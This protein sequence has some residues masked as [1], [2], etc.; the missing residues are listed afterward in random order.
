M[1]TGAGSAPSRYPSV[2]SDDLL[3]PAATRLVHVGPQKTGSTA[4]QVALAAA[5][6]DLTAYG[7]YYPG[8]PYRRRKA[9]WALG[10]PGSPGGRTFPIGHWTRLVEEV[11]D[12]GDARVCV[13]DEN[14]ARAEGPVLERIVTDLG[15]PQVHV[16]AVARRLDRVLPSQWQERVKWGHTGDFDGWL[17]RVLGDDEDDRERWDAWQGHDSARLVER[18]ARVVGPERFTLVI[19]DETDREQLFRVFAAM[20]GL[21]PGVLGA[22]SRRSNESLSWSELEVL[23]N[24]RALYVENGWPVERFGERLRPIVSSLR[25]RSTPPAGPRTPPI[26]AWARGRLRALSEERAAAVAALPVRVVGDPASLQQVDD[27]D[28]TTAADL[29]LPVDRVLAIVEGVLRAEG[30][31]DVA[32]E[33]DAVP[34]PTPRERDRWRLRR[35]RGT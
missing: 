13:S 17:R 9:G 6:D 5:R 32:A 7:A 10:L 22:A 4:V 1:P 28:D 26:P 15:G 27:A 35:S 8:G 31:F 21:P 18:W 16:V 3:L 23:R 33:E 12:A 14:F 2:V 19:A 20:L 29:T 30:V 25:S 34:D 24:L 11:R